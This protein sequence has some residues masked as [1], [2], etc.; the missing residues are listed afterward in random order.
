[1]YDPDLK[2]YQDMLAAR[3]ALGVASAEEI[4][5]AEQRIAQEDA[6]FAEGVARYDALFSELDCG[7]EEIAP[8]SRVWDRIAQAVDDFEKSPATQTVR[9]A[10]MGW[11]PF[12]P[13]IGRKLLHADT[14]AGVQIVLYKVA[15]GTSFGPH[16]HI[17]T[18]ECLVLD[19]EIEVDGVV[20]GSGDLH[21]AFANTRHGVLTSRTGA[22]LYVRADLHMQ[23]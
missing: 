23:S 13:G 12:A 6:A 21:M 5:I 3:Y 16:G 22:I 7:I 15:A 14:D 8:P 4:A 20:A 2:E 17:I 10:A 9:S 18:E 1:M 19:G 11:E